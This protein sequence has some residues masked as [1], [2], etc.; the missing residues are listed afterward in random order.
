MDGQVGVDSKLGVGSTFWFVVRASAPG[1][2]EPVP[3]PAVEPLSPGAAAELARRA[4]D[5]PRRLLYIEDNTASRALLEQLVAHRGGFE[6]VAAGTVTDGLDL[7]RRTDP[8]TV[9][10]DL[11]LPDGSGE[12]VVRALHADPRT[13]S[14]P[15]VVLT[16]DATPERRK[17]LLDMGVQAYLTKPVDAAALFV[18]LESVTRPGD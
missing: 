4:E 7:A 10:L 5:A 1:R 18:A 8:E 17:T 16:A 15:V 6:V 12:D 13:A 9:L 14:I 3:A 2:P 11:H